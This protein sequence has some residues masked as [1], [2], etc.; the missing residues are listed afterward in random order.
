MKSP[1]KTNSDFVFKRDAP[2]LPRHLEPLEC[3]SSGGEI[4]LIEER[5]VQDC[6][7]TNTKTGA[8]R[9]EG[10]VLERVQLAGGQLGSVVWRDVRLVGCDLANLLA[11]RMTLVRVELIDCRLTGLRASSLDWQDVLVQ[12]GDARYAQLQGGNFRACE[13]KTSNWQE[14]DLRGA[15]LSGAVFRSCDLTRADLQSAKLNHADFRGSEVEGMLVGVNDLRGTIVDPAQAMVFARLLG[16][17]I[18]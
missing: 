10:S 7:W 5:H 6:D 2:D 18:R 13:F 9:M 16:L 3:G 4:T 8:L 12:N 1:R 15:D 14:A 11:H 17:Q